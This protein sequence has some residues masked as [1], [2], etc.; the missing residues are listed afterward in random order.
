[1]DTQSHGFTPIRAVTVAGVPVVTFRILGPLE[2]VAS[3]RPVECGTPMQRTVLAMLL[4]RPRQVVSSDRLIDELWGEDPPSQADHS[5][6][7]YVSNLRRRFREAELSERIETRTPGYVLHVEADEIDAS[8]FEALFAE[9]RTSD[10]RRAVTLLDDALQLWRGAAFAEFADRE[11]FSIQA[12]RLEELRLSAVEHRLERL[13]RLGRDDEMIPEVES[14]IALQPLRERP[15]ALAMRALDNVGRKAD[16]LRVYR[17]YREL[18]TEELGVEPSG[19]LKELES[20]ILGTH[21]E[22]APTPLAR[23]LVVTMPEMTLGTFDRAPGET[24]TYGIL[25]DGPVL[26]KP[27][28]HFSSLDLVAA[29]LDYRRS[30]LFATLARDFRVVTHDRY[31]V[32]LSKG[33]VTDFSH[34]TSVNELVGLIEHLELRD[35][36]MYGESAAGSIVLA[37]TAQMPERVARLVLL[38]TCVSARNF[39]TQ[40]IRD[41][42]VPL[43]RDTWGLATTWLTSIHFPGAS[44]EIHDADA[45]LQRHSATGEVAAGYLEQYFETDV[46]DLLPQVE[47]PA[48]VLHYQGDRTAPFKAA[49]QAAKLLPNARLVPLEGNAHTPPPEDVE[50]VASMV[51]R[52]VEET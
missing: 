15:R 33:P 1:M 51:Y 25:G 34:E 27:Q 29:G 28:G 17:T 6:Q 40:S 7:T 19:S 21:G 31:G 47:V 42:F 2:V 24:V 39:Y 36:T 18:L 52:F 5:L 45:R 13:Q 9:A 49:Q 43:A 41:H 46:S 38:G 3:G 23:P 44:A 22:A 26:V 8:R 20:S 10:D 32:G 4:A 48:L 35:I 30:A 14:L 37:A 16:A 50:K 12:I 11:A